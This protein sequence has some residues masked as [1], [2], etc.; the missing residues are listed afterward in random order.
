MERRPEDARVLYFEGAGM[1]CDDCNDI[2]NPRI[3]SAFTADDGKRY[4]VE[5]HGIQYSKDWLKVYPELCVGD[6][7]AWVDSCHEITNTADIDA[8]YNRHLIERVLLFPYTLEGICEAI[9]KH[10]NCS[11]ERI[12]VLP[13][14][15]GYRVFTPNW[16][17]AERN[18]DKY[19]YGDEFIYDPESTAKAQRIRDEEEQ[20]QR[21]M[22][23]KYP[24][25]SAYR[26]ADDPLLLHID[27]CRQGLGRL[28]FRLD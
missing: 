21:D 7:C 4:Y 22:G 17:S 11:F 14:L 8:I 13:D 24:C 9:N 10:L 19:C 5:F 1:W 23:E 6:R 27:H 3:R 20:K 18:V 2:G 15:S 26:D 16:R 28:T 25:L 12:V